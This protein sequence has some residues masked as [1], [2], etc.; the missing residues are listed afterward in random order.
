MSESFSEFLNLSFF[1]RLLALSNIHLGLVS[2]FYV[3]ALV[4]KV[5]PMVSVVEGV[6]FYSDKLRSISGVTFAKIS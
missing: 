1:A 3:K 5:T 4:R 6:I 2:P